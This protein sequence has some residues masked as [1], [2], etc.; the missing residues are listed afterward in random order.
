MELTRT[1]PDSRAAKAVSKDSKANGHAAASKGASR[2]AVSS[3]IRS[4]PASRRAASRRRTWTNG[5]L[6]HSGRT[7]LL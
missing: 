3:R 5:R 1:V 2:A 4:N 7:Y 6:G